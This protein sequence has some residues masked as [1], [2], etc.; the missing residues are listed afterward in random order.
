M[1]DKLPKWV[2]WLFST[3][4]WVPALLATLLTACM[5]WVSLPRQRTATNAIAPQQPDPN[6]YKINP[7]V[8]NGT[9]TF[10]EFHLAVDEFRCKTISC[11]NIFDTAVSLISDDKTKLE[12]LVVF[13]RWIASRDAAITCDNRLEDYS[14]SIQKITDRYLMCQVLNVGSPAVIRIDCN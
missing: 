8:A 2:A 1:A 10:V 6:D 4:W 5:I 11:S 7:W 13:D 3:P 14:T 9:Q 12:I